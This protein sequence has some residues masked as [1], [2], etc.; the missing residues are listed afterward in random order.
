M[1]FVLPH[2]PAM[3]KAGLGG[4]LHSFLES[5]FIVSQLKLA[6]GVSTSIKLSWKNILRPVK[7]YVRTKVVQVGEQTTGDK[8]GG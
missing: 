4:R 6:F 5:N 8:D 2:I 1:W 7:S 3:H